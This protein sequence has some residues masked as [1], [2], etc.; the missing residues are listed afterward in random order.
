MSKADE[1]SSCCSSST[2]DTLDPSPLLMLPD[3]AKDVKHT[4]GELRPPGTWSGAI[5]KEE[6]RRLCARVCVCVCV[7]VC[8]YVYN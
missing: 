5:D 1:E 2:T 3:E 8:V 7:C 6:K 4:Y